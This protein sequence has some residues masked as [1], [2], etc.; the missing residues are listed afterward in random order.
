M[1]QRNLTRRQYL[2]S[3]CRYY[4]GESEPPRSLPEGCAL[5]WDYEWHWVLWSLKNDPMME[6]FQRKIEEFHLENKEGDDTPLTMKALLL[7]RYLHWCGAYASIEE[8]L[9]HFEKWYE[10]HYLIWST[11]DERKA[12]A[13]PIFGISRHRMGVD[14]KGVTTLVTFMGC[15]L[16]CRYCLNDKCHEDIYEE[17]GRTLRRGILMLTPQQLYDMVKQDNIYFQATGGGICFG[18][19]EPTMQEQFIIEFAKLSPKNWKIT[20]ETSLDCSFNTIK[21]L[22]PYVDEW[23]VDIKSM[24]ADIYYRY[25][26]TNSAVHQHLECAKRL[27]SPDKVTIK[28]P[29]IPDFTTED[30]VRESVRELRELG[31]TNIV[32]CEYVKRITRITK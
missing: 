1:S 25:T 24:N 27:L 20:L 9:K 2:L 18:G 26:G 15:P 22:A 6:Q 8:A 17:D 12:Y 32:E 30:D 14:G 4:N 23:I 29:H 31:F 16:K 19:G 5:M 13:S 10:S 7:N 21:A 28:V 3:Q 11:N